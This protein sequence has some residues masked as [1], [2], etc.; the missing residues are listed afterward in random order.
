[1]VGFHMGNNQIVG[2]FPGQGLF[3]IFHIRVFFSSVNRVHYGDFIIQN[4]IRVISD[5]VG[6][7]ERSFK[8]VNILIVHAYINNIVGYHLKYLLFVIKR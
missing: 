2:T 3:Q 8:E 6:N 7:R 1:M 5:T 4:H